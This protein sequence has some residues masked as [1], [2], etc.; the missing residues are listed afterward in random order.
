MAPQKI[1]TGTALKKTTAVKKGQVVYLPAAEV[2]LS[3]GIVT[4]QHV[5][6]R[7]SEALNHAAR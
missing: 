4:A 6:E 3:G 2:Y 7:V 5:V 1:L